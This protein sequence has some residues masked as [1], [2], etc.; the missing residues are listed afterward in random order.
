MLDNFIRGG[1]V[2]LHNFTMFKQV[3]GKT[4]ICALLLA[5]LTSSYL[6]FPA[7]A[8]LDYLAAATYVKAL[9]VREISA[10]TSKIFARRS[11]DKINAYYRGGL[12]AKN[13]SARKL[14]SRPLFRNAY[15]ELV[16]LAI[17]ILTI[18]GLFVCG[19]FL[20]I[21]FIWSY[22]GKSSKESRLSLIHI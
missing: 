22:F 21:Y 7:A 15:Q 1:Q 18:T 9:S 13:I 14:I 3:I 16:N 2:F 8:R 12:Y 5:T 6:Y 17:K 11:S 10:A 20:L 19:F 4:L